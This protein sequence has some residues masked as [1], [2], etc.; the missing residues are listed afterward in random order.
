[1]GRHSTATVLNAPIAPTENP[2]LTPP[3]SPPS[4]K[5]KRETTPPA[6]IE[7]DINA[8]EPPSKKA[9]RKRRKDEV[10]TAKTTTGIDTS[11]GKVHVAEIPDQDAAIAE[12]PSKRSDYGIWIGNLSWMTTKDELRNFFNGHMSES[13]ASITR[14]HLP[15]P[16][17]TTLTNSRQKIKPHNRGFAYVDF[18]TAE[19]LNNA[20]SLSETLFSGRKVLIKDAKN[21]EGRPEKPTNGLLKEDTLAGD[22]P[23]KRIFVGN[24][25]FEVTKEEIWGHFAQCGAIVDVFLATFEDSGKCKGYGWVTFAE[26]EAARIAVKGWV[27]MYPNLDEE[28]QAEDEDDVE[29]LG[30]TD[31]AARRAMGNGEKAGKRPRP[32][33]W[34]VN[35]FQGR[36]LRMEFAEGKDV[37]YQK[38]YG[39]GGAAAR[40][41]NAKGP[42][43][44]E[45]GT[46]ESGKVVGRHARRMD[47]GRNQP[48][49]RTVDARMI[50]PGAALAAAPRLTGGIV[51]SQGK[52]ITFG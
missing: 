9:L 4:K 34:W 25:G 35:R 24:L 10:A 17:Q 12:S 41:G 16:S 48:K 30:K 36:P 31:E 50:K 44:D 37:R 28:D 51:E 20:L 11:N 38:R 49:E 21:F 29:E 46:Y 7:I 23:S 14:I 27:E 3:E 19:A 15:P 33:K 47:I 18:S 5:R 45:E 43:V 39:K 1:M 6:V 42:D 32:R 2:I 52:K 13:G 26:M 40:K 8:P 22:S